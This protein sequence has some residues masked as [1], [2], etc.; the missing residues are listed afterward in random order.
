MTESGQAR[1]GLGHPRA[2]REGYTRWARTGGARFSASSST[3]IPPR[4]STARPRP[5]R[6]AV[7]P[8]GS[9]NG[10][11]HDRVEGV[12]GA[13]GIV[14]VVLTEL[15]TIPPHVLVQP[16]VDSRLS[17]GSEMHGH[18]ASGI[19]T[20][21]NPEDVKALAGG[22][23]QRRPA[24]PSARIAIMIDPTR[25]QEQRLQAFVGPA[26]RGSRGTAPGGGQR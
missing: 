23:Q 17:P 21:V 12:L 3:A 16:I 14:T 15:V 4:R 20:D 13:G 24:A 18:A 8:A 11:D 7:T 6:Y 26:P 22:G 19:S 25:A 5:L 1:S 9:C 10:R 2:W